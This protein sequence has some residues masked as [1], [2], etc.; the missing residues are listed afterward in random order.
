MESFFGVLAWVVLLGCLPCGFLLARRCVKNVAGRVV[1]TLVFGVV[2]LVIGL[3]A[4]VSG[5][6]AMGGKMDFH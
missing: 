3:I 2:F 5:C 1:L 6:T 4:V